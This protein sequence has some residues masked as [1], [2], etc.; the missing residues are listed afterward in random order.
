MK[1][2][3]FFLLLAIASSSHAQESITDLFKYKV[4]KQ[5]DQVPK[6]NIGKAGFYLEKSAKFQ[7]TAIGCGVASASMILAS[8]L[9]DD[10]YEVDKK[11]GE[12]SKKSNGA[13]TA[14]VVGGAATLIA[15][16]CCEFISI[17][18]KMKSG[19]YLQLHSNGT[20]GS[21]ALVF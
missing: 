20:G 1:N 4:R 10:K 15:A 19:K 6:T 3:I 21:V 13:K 17:N 18:Y 14:L 12:F 16:V 11:T 8:S 7:Y 5:A 9:I 2:I